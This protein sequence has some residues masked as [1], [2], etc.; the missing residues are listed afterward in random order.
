MDLLI[1]AV[2]RS[3]CCEFSHRDIQACSDQRKAPP[4]RTLGG[5][6]TQLSLPYLAP[7]PAISLPHKQRF[8]GGVCLAMRPL[9]PRVSF[10]NRQV[11]A[12][13]ASGSDATTRGSSGTKDICGAT[14][15]TTAAARETRCAR[16]SRDGHGQ[17]G[18][19]EAGLA[20]SHQS[21]PRLFEPRPIRRAGFPLSLRSPPQSGPTWRNIRLPRT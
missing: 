12:T 4:E 3:E 19:P 18:P 15:S 17:C 11:T 14:T 10:R 1:M 21:R 9:R 5:G 2:V 13:G 16:V 7:P 20:P 6:F 8:H